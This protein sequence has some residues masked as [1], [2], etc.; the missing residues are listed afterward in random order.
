MTT[1]SNVTVT[2]AGSVVGI[3]N[4]SFAKALEDKRGPGRPGAQFR[5]YVLP[6]ESHVITYLRKE[7]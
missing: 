7:S 5:S 4:P 2:G 1:E 6:A 3:N